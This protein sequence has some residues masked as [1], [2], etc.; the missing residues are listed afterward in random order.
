MRK[1][2]AI[3]KEDAVLDFS[4]KVEDFVAANGV[5]AALK[6]FAWAMD[7]KD[8]AQDKLAGVLSKLVVD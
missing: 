4:R 6:A 3:I 8:P 5:K 1:L 7:K 2:E